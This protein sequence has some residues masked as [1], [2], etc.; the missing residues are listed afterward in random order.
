MHDPKSALKTRLGK[1]R[2]TIKPL[3]MRY[4]GE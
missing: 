4:N 2:P 1:L 3:E